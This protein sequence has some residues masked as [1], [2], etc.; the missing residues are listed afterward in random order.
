ME[1]VAPKVVNGE[2][3]EEDIEAG[4]TLWDTTLIMYVL[5]GDLSMNMVK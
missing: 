4:V 1:F 3:E 5:G 2:I